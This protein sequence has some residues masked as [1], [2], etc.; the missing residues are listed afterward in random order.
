MTVA[1]VERYTEGAV[2]RMKSKA[3]F[4][5]MLA[6]MIGVSVARLIGG[7]KVK[8]PK[9]EEVYPSLFNDDIKAEDNVEDR[10]EASVNNF[11]EFALQLNAKRREGVET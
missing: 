10:T 8:Y 1:E 5:Y 7:D 6:D 3:Q 2:W 4:D 11:M 9:I